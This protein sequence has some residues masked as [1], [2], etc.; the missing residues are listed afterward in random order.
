MGLTLGIGFYE[1]ALTGAAAIFTVMALMQ[2]IDDRMRRKTHFLEVYIELDSRILLGELLR[3]VR[4]LDIEVRDVQ[5][6]Y[7]ADTDEGIHAY[8]ATLKTQKRRNREDILADIR[9]LEGISYLEEL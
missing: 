7:D 9:A 2:R 5:R 6:E 8:I 1:A 3:K 4:E